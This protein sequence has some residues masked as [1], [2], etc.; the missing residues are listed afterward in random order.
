MT[1][2]PV[3]H[4]RSGGTASLDEVL[5][6]LFVSGAVVVVATPD[7]YAGTLTLS[8]RVG[9]ERMVESRLRQFTAGRISARCALSNLGTP[10]SG[11]PRGPDRV[12]QWPRGVVGSITH[13]DG[14]CVAVVARASDCGAIGIDAEP[15]SPLDPELHDLVCRPAER[16]H[17]HGLPTLPGTDWPKVAFSVKESFYKAWFPVTGTPLDFT[18]V[19]LTVDPVNRKVRFSLLRD[20]DHAAW[21]GHA[22][23]RFEI[24]GEHVVTGVTMPCRQ[25]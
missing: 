2:Q 24:V 18:D 9:T 4:D 3:S 5:T 13:C 8:E 16:R 14:L 15:A 10:V 25:V 12:P 21:G 20:D 22:Q 1:G 23:G 7:M 19:E 6:S 17:L 11:I